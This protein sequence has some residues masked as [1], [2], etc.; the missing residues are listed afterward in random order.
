MKAR[1]I[2]YGLR[3]LVLSGW[4]FLPWVYFYAEIQGNSAPSGAVP[5]PVDWLFTFPGLLI[6][7]YWVLAF[8]TGYL[9]GRLGSTRT[10]R[11]T[12][13][14]AMPIATLTAY[15]PALQ[16][17]SRPVQYVVCLLIYPVFAAVICGLLAL[18]TH[19]RRTSLRKPAEG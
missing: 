16:G 4:P 1:H 18:A 7:T 15:S 12:G 5:S 10:I 9:I 3:S 17:A 6:I 19:A 14:V 8:A 11:I 2:C 13:L